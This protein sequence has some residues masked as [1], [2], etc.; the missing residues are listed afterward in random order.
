MRF[1]ARCTC[2]ARSIK[3]ISYRKRDPV[4]YSA[5]HLSFK[6]NPVEAIPHWHAGGLDSLIGLF[7]LKA[8]HAL[9]GLF[10]LTYLTG[11]LWAEARA[12]CKCQDRSCFGML[13]R[14]W[15]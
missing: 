14:K 5:I 11:C 15:K 1:K 12:S 8:I 9:H 3:A 7:H 4:F 10:L 13:L 2:K 6:A